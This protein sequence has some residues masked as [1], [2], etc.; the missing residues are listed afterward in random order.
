MRPLLRPRRGD[1]Q[2]RRRI[3][4]ELRFKNRVALVTG[5]SS[6]IGRASAVAL[7]AQGARVIIAGRRADRLAEVVGRIQSGGGEA[8]AVTGD[9]RDEAVCA[10]GV[11]TAA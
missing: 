5:G 3:M 4:T 8:M 10:E 1:D 2:H 7:A 9:V 6:G 11:A